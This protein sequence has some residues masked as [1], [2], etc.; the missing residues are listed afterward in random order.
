MLKDVQSGK[1]G[2][3]FNKIEVSIDE[4]NKASLELF[5]SVG[6]VRTGKDEELFKYE[7]SKG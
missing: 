4:K 5:E 2:L 3:D 7:Y 1:F 6:F